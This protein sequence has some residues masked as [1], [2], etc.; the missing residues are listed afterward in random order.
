MKQKK[1]LAIIGTAGRRDDASK[2]TKAHWDNMVEIAL[3]LVN[4]ESPDSLVSGGA[5]WADH[6]TVHL[7]N[8]MAAPLPTRIIL[9]E[10]PRDWE[11]T[12]HYHQMFSTVIGYSSLREMSQLQQLGKIR[13]ERKGSF[14]E[15]NTEVANAATE[16]LAM[17]FGNGPHP[18]DGGTSDTVNKLLQQGKSGWHLD[19]NTGKV[20]RLTAVTLW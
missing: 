6:V 5:A 8:L 3:G 18:K 14:K 17:T 11:T 7:A 12:R 20:F 19:L 15:R 1:I 13:V 2:L 9:P 10:N 16:F 4:K